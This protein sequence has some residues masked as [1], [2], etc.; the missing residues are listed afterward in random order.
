MHGGAWVHARRDLSSLLSK[1]M[2]AGIFLLFGLV[3]AMTPLF[4]RACGLLDG[5][6]TW[7]CGYPR[8]DVCAARHY[9][10]AFA[11]R[12]LERPHCA[13]AAAEATT[14]R[15]TLGWHVKAVL[16]RALAR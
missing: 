3:H 5:V 4:C 9:A 7:C 16:D 6:F 14:P 12:A 15:T 2:P 1:R 13:Y 8:C 10:N 11:S